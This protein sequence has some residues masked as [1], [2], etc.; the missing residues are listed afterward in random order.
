MM[1]RATRLR[2]Q[3]E[4]LKKPLALPMH[5]PAVANARLFALKGDSMLTFLF[6]HS[7]AVAGVLLAMLIAATLLSG[8]WVI[9]ED[10]SGLVI[11]RFGPPLA[12]GRFNRPRRGSGLPGADAFAW[13]AFRHV[14][15]ALQDRED[16]GDG[17]A[18]E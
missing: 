13:M 7:F 11:K 4:T 15:M 17:R 9:A 8:T 16:P 6:D 1:I 2:K 14:A 5:I 12:S 18:D 10:E 3:A